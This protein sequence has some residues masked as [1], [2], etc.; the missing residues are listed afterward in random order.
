[1]K[2]SLI[3]DGMQVF[4]TQGELTWYLW[5]RGIDVNQ[6][7]GIYK[8]PALHHDYRCIGES[9][10]N[11]VVGYTKTRIGLVSVTIPW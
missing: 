9:R 11:R 6:P 7:F 10:P 1:M 5:E 4:R 2:V 8:D 3:V